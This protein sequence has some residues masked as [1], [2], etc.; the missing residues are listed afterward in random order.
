MFAKQGI[1][2]LLNLNNSSIWKLYSFVISNNQ[3]ILSFSQWDSNRR[4]IWLS[5]INLKC[6]YPFVRKEF[7]AWLA[8]THTLFWLSVIYVLTSTSTNACSIQ[9]IIWFKMLISE[10]ILKVSG[11]ERIYYI[12]V[13]PCYQR[14]Y[15][16]FP[17]I[18]GLTEDALQNSIHCREVWWSTHE[19][20][21]S[22]SVFDSNSGK[23]IS[24]QIENHHPRV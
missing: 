8:I 24:D 3:I 10:N 7:Y 17:T 23:N 5:L 11:V 19:I 18:L 16:T 4:S 15:F 22:V 20:P 6:L 9:L 13:Y 12:F 1:I 14:W 2:V 21:S